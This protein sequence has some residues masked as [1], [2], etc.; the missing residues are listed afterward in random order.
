MAE[1]C[2]AT[3]L[4]T[5]G[6]CFDGMSSVQKEAVKIYLLTVIAGVAADPAALATLAKCFEGLSAVQQ[7][8]IQTYLLCQIAN[9]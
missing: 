2:T 1:T 5:Q 6:K 8:A 4:A 3:S 9:G 7:R